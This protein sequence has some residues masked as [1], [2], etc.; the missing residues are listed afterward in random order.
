MNAPELRDAVASASRIGGRLRESLADLAA[1]MPISPAAVENM[2]R[3]LAV[4]TDAFL[5]RFESLVSQLQ[6]QV[7]PRAAAF[8][9]EDPAPL[10]RR[11][12]MEL[13]DKLRIL[14][15]ADAFRDIARLRN[16]LSHA[17]THDPVRIARRLNEAYAAAPTVLRALE[18]AEAW[19]ARRLNP[20]ASP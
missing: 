6:D 16:R 9:N 12:V 18:T 13:M 4:F 11:D 7:W 15:S 5:K 2:D 1:V 3:H 10:S 8:E 17:Y 20:P 14:E 19:A